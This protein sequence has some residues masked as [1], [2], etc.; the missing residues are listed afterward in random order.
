MIRLCIIDD[1]GDHIAALQARLQ[2][3][4]ELTCVDWGQ[5]LSVSLPLGNE[6]IA[7]HEYTYEEQVTRT[8]TAIHKNWDACDLFLLDWSLLGQRDEQDPISIK[9]VHKVFEDY[10]S[11]KDDVDVQRKHIVIITGKGSGN[12]DFDLSNNPVMKKIMC[13]DKPTDEIRTI[14]M[15]SCPCKP[16]RIC[17]ERGC[18]EYR[19][20][21][22][23]KHDRSSCLG[24]I[25]TL[26]DQVIVRGE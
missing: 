16:G 21:S 20:D 15:S 12:I 3:T 24:K 26:I 23:I 6:Q 5:S 13:V 14:R 25:I 9:A 4:P 2:A 8:V 1:I 11:H 18:S 10:A 17:A 22:L 19:R 7:G